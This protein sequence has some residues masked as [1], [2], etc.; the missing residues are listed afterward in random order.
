M[1]DTLKKIDTLINYLEKEQKEL[2][3]SFNKIF[4][5][6]DPSITL[7]E[8]IE[9]PEIKEIRSKL[10]INKNISLEMNFIKYLIKIKNTKNNSIDQSKIMKQNTG[11]LLQKIQ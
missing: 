6:L 8:M 9:I 3:N 2:E 1:Q 5:E 10:Q 7:S 4:N 11:N